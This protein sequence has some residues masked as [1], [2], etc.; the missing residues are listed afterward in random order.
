LLKATS[1]KV[2][3]CQPKL[4]IAYSRNKG[5]I[6]CLILRLSRLLLAAKPSPAKW[7]WVM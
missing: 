2:W 1:R 3:Q 4:L 6:P 5:L 7:A